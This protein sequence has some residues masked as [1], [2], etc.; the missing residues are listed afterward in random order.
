MKGEVKVKIRWIDSARGSINAGV[1][2]SSEL[3]P[4]NLNTEEM[5]VIRLD[6]RS[7]VSNGTKEWK[8]W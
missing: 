7:Q 6:G 3:S 2:F 8:Y 1:C 4:Y 5:C